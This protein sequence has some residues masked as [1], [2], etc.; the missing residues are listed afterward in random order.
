M[1]TG[2]RTTGPV[3]LSHDLMDACQGADVIYTDVWASMGQEEEAD[4]RSKKFQAYQVNEKLLEVAD[5]QCII[6]HCLPAHYGEEIEYAVSRTPNS[7]IFDQ[8]ENRLHAQKGLLALIG[9]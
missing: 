2:R 1:T 7:V 3:V 4:E 6:M 8:A 5:D 9:C